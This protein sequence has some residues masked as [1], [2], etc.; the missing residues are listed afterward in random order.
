MF[1]RDT[2]RAICTANLDHLEIRQR[3]NLKQLVKLAVLSTFLSLI[4]HKGIKDSVIS[5][6][7]LLD[8][9]I[10]AGEGRTAGKKCTPKWCCLDK[11]TNDGLS[12][13]MNM[14]Q[15]EATQDIEDELFLKVFWM[16]QMKAASEKNKCSIRWHPLIIR[17]ALYLHH[18]SSGAYE[19]LRKSGVLLLPII[20]YIKRLP[21]FVTYIISGL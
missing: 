19:T 17:W 2:K 7:Q 6:P 9:K 13:L 8:D 16:Q 3:N 1:V 5:T 12:Q 20:T 18:R 4:L 11:Q 10:P 15:K 14:Y 21:P